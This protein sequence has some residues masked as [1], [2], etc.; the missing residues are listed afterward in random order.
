MNGKK[1]TAIAVKLFSSFVIAQIGININVF[2]SALDMVGFPANT[3]KLDGIISPSLTG[4][5]LRAKNYTS[6]Q[7]GAFVYVTASDSAPT[8]Q[9]INV[10]LSGYDYFDGAK[11]VRFSDVNQGVNN[12]AF[13]RLTGNSGTNPVTNFLGTTD[14][15]PLVLKTNNT[16]RIRLANSGNLG[17]NH[18]A[19][20]EKTNISNGNILPVSYRS[21]LQILKT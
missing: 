16:E 5:Q 14:N 10:T 20:A 3:A 11:W 2:T 6:F 13:W 21:L 1:N 7:T 15:Q 12:R 17:M 18:T 19:P 8:G 9:T 4:N